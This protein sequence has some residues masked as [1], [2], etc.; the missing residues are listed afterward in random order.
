[1]RFYAACL[2]S[3]N[4]GVLFGR[5]IDADSDVDVMAAEVS[6][7][8]RESPY[9]NVTVVAPD[10]YEK[11]AI[12]E[13]WSRVPHSGM[14]SGPV[15][16]PVRI[17]DYDD[18]KELCEVHG[19]APLQVPSAEEWAAHDYEGLPSSF[20]EYSGL[21]PIAD[22]VEMTESFDYLDSDDL[23]EI[24]D[25]FA[26]LDDAREALRDRFAGIYESFRD[27]S[28]ETADEAIACLSGD[29]EIPDFLTNYFDYESYA[30]D[31]ALETTAVSVG[32]N[33]AIFHS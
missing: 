6:A 5:W 3:Y 13:G 22:F 14:F 28:D 25:Y 33:V 18:W 10:G 23:A 12:A 1:M 32:S 20:G 26:K 24:V 30:R 9:P 27:Y 15:G 7:M 2:A 29:S 21:Q 16:S 19:I 4:N 11:A 31:L 17:A 8:L